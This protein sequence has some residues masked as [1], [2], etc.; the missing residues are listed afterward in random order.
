MTENGEG[1]DESAPHV[2][3]SIFL[4]R[5]LEE[6]LA[7]AASH[8]GITA[9]QLIVQLLEETLRGESEAPETPTP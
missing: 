7:R 6:S 3:R 5:D 8:R 4:P 9:N 1:F 2:R